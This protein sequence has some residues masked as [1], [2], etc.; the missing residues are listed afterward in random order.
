[1]IRAC[2][3]TEVM[4]MPWQKEQAATN[5]SNAPKVFQ[6]QILLVIMLTPSGYKPFFFSYHGV[7]CLCEPPFIVKGVMVGRFVINII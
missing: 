7:L 1:M 4:H 2:F 6:A 3:L 5:R